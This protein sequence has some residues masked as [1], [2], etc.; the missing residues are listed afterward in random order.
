MHF[1]STEAPTSRSGVVPGSVATWVTSPQEGAV[2]VKQ[3]VSVRAETRACEVNSIGMRLAQHHVVCQLGFAFPTM[4][5][6][7]SS[8]GPHAPVPHDLSRAVASHVARERASVVSVALV[9]CLALSARTAFCQERVDAPNSPSDE[10]L[11]EQRR[12]QAAAKYQRG[13]DAYAAAQYKDAAE[14]FLEADKLSPS[15]PLSFNIARAEDHL[16]NAAGAL[17]WY[18]DYLR[19]APTAKNAGE[20][21][22][23]IAAL[24]SSLAERGVQQLTVL[25]NPEGATVQI[26]D[27][28]AVIAP[29][30]GELSPGRHHLTFSRAGYADVQRDIE[31]GANEPIDVSVQLEQKP[32][33][34]APISEKA[35]T[36]TSYAAPARG[37]R[38]GALPWVTLGVGGAALGGALTFEL[39]RRRAENDAKHASQVGYQAQL[40][41]EQSRQT[42]ARIFLGVGGAF[43]VAGGLMMLFDT[44]PQSQSTGAALMCLPH[45][46]MASALGRF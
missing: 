41:R 44:R 32:A 43:V 45:A 22:T 7:I 33:V 4:T 19:R 24:A 27:Q 20:V 16:G 13:V 8:T 5:D 12:A 23:K 2:F 1:V 17:R 18:R 28:P 26:D 30:T 3:G 14:L 37:P 39:L 31:L 36:N 46:C 21:R 15:A 11:A 25:S 40:D 35:A 10:S 9:L 6:S 29:W 38:L 34:P 42:T